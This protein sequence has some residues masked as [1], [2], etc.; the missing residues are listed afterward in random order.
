MSDFEKGYREV[1]ARMLVP[2]VDAMQ[3]GTVENEAASV[4]L[5]LERH[6]AR[7]V[8]IEIRRAPVHDAYE[9][10]AGGIQ[11]IDWRDGYEFM[12]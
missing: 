1:W 6:G 4:A 3:K 10:V 12:P 8:R 9:V 2:F 7:D 11:G 5:F